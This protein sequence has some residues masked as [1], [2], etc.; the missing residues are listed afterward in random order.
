MKN[1]I[2]YL[3]SILLLMS[4]MNAFAHI[5]NC[6]CS[7]LAKGCYEIP[8]IIHIIHHPDDVYPNGTN[9]SCDQVCSQM[10]VLNNDFLKKN[11]DVSSVIPFYTDRVG[12]VDVSFYI[13]EVKRVPLP[14]KYSFPIY[15]CISLDISPAATSIIDEMIPLNIWVTDLD[16][17][18]FA[19]VLATTVTGTSCD[20][21]MACDDH[22]I[23]VD[24]Q[25]FGN[26]DAYDLDYSS[27][28]GRVVTHEVGHW[29]GLRHP[30][31]GLPQWE[32]P[33]CDCIYD[34][35]THRSDRQICN[36][37]EEFHV[38]SCNDLD[39]PMNLQNFMGYSEDPGCRVMFT[40]GQ[41]SVMRRTV[42]LKNNIQNYI[43]ID[44]VIAQF[45]PCAII[46][47]RVDPDE[48]GA[49]N[50]SI[51]P[52]PVNDRLN[53]TYQEPIG[54]QWNYEMVD[55]IGKVVKQGAISKS[56]DLSQLQEGLYI[57]RLLEGNTLLEH[58]KLVK[59]KN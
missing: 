18:N 2:T 36:T 48:P 19:S 43:I 7:N 5:D 8:V 14:K 25:A 11:T 28:D 34:T 10:E 29:L 27:S 44:N 58:R 9:I 38:N 53:L 23:F 24:L 20:I 30:W 31:G 12:K 42:I 50:F 17:F 52:N 59:L 41:A 55:F 21:P 13:H 51:F 15:D 1:T 37:T 56:L 39:G 33:W 6:S 4:T 47:P 16:L 46:K 54:V 26:G 22:G 49:D 45:N 32:N 40:K 3:L 35:P 57:I